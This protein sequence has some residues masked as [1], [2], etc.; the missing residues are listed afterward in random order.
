[1]LAGSAFEIVHHIRSFS[2][3][4]HRSSAVS[5][6][7]SIR[8]YQR[9]ATAGVGTKPDTVFLCATLWSMKARRSRATQSGCRSSSLKV[10]MVRRRRHSGHSEFSRPKLA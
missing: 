9:D 1:M 4:I 6:T 3:W 2:R 8:L 10:A 5:V 7:T